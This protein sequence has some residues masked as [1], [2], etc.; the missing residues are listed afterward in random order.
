MDSA[1]TALFSTQWD[2][3]SDL[4]K[5]LVYGAQQIVNCENHESGQGGVVKIWSLIQVRE[6]PALTVGGWSDRTP[7]VFLPVLL[8]AEQIYC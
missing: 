4:E 3:M 2:A 5:R 1:A 8:W 7:A 6:L